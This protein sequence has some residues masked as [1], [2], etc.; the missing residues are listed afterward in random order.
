MKIVK[1]CLFGKLF[2]AGTI[3]LMEDI[4]NW[5]QMVD[6]KMTII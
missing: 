2:R 1:I 6:I 5:T 4:L 3:K